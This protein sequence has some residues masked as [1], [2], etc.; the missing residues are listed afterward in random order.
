MD[1]L[2][3]SGKMWE[4]GLRLGLKLVLNRLNEY[5]LDVWDGLTWVV[6]RPFTKLPFPWTNG[7][8][9]ELQ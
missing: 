6:V 4:M 2:G 5:V 1:Q 7:F 9:D 8:V 3:G